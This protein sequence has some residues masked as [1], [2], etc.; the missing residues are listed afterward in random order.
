MFFLSLSDFYMF[1]QERVFR[2]AIYSASEQEEEETVVSGTAIV[3]R[4]RRR[5]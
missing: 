2:K 1:E 5:K 3:Y 4:V